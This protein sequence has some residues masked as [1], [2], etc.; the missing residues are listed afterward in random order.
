MKI[1]KHDEGSTVFVCLLCGVSRPTEAYPFPPGPPEV[2]DR[3]VCQGVAFERKRRRCGGAWTIAGTRMTVNT[4]VSLHTA[5]EPLEAIQHWYPHVTLEQVGAAVALPK[6]LGDRW[7]DSEDVQ[8]KRPLTFSMRHFRCSLVTAG[9][10]YKHDPS[11]EHQDEDRDR[12]LRP[13]SGAGGCRLRA[14]V[15]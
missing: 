13:A 14:G 8:E 11:C 12:E 4:L 15:R 2:Q 7:L 1:C 5:G 3:E 6:Q 9:M 10:V